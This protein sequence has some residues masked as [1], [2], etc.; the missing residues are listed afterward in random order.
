M[1]VS[2]QSA[3]SGGTFDGFEA[4]PIGNLSRF[5]FALM[6]DMAGISEQ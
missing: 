4:R 5:G 2:G 6:S 3:G 1:S